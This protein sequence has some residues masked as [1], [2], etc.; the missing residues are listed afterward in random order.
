M[1]RALEDAG[2]LEAALYAAQERTHDQL[3]A[4][5][6]RGCGFYEAWEKVRGK[7]L[8][9]PD[10]RAVPILPFDPADLVPPA[11]L[12]QYRRRGA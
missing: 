9:L 8:L 6:S 7:W 12:L 5:L 4:L 2:K 10:E 11:K 3:L 1:Y